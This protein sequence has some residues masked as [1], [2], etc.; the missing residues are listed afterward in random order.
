MKKKIRVLKAS[1]TPYEVGF[2]HGRSYPNEIRHYT[3]ERVQLVC[4]GLWS[5]GPLPREEVLA[6]AEACLPAH[7]AYAPELFE[8]MQG[9]AAATE[10]PLAAMLIVSGFTDFVDTVYSVTRQ[11]AARPPVDDCTAFIVPDSAA[12]GAGFFGQTWDM[13]DTATQYV[14][15]LD[16]QPN[17]APRSLVFTTTGCIGQIGM[18]E[19]GI[20]VGINNLLGADG[21]IGITWPFVVR[22]ILQQK[23]IE[24]ALACITEAKLA[25]AHN[26][27]LFDGNG[28]GYNVEAMSSHHVVTPL[29]EEPLIHTNHCLLPQTKQFAQERPPE[30]Q[31]SSEARLD[32]AGDLLR[33]RPLTIQHLI[34]LTRDPQAICVRAQ[35]PFHV[36]SCGAAIMQPKTGTFWAVWGLPSENEYEQFHLATE[37]TEE[38][39]KIS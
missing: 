1:G 5:G 39:E 17:G 16:V 12:N 13:H 2:A 32:R 36:E 6:I 26:Y 9:I 4:D 11:K 25:G 10:L 34:A 24:D 15:L 33:K 18:N 28:R 21:Q 29:A 30:A 20:C 31:V 8:E 38:R 37:D 22:K 14:I 7:E 27:L 19:H 3:K 35:P 23:N